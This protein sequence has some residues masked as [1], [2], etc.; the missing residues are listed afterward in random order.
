MKVTTNG[1]KYDVRWERWWI[2]N[3]Y[4]KK[5]LHPSNVE[6]STCPMFQDGVNLLKDKLMVT[7]CIISDI[8]DR[9]SGR[10]KY[11]PIYS[12]ISVQGVKDSPNKFFG[13]KYSFTRALALFSKNDRS[14][15]WK[16]FVLNQVKT[17]VCQ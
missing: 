17:E 2:R 13:R 3:D 1:K 9:K 10:E 16:V 4:S 12:G 15:F 14:E 8:D 7:K 6:K 11:N 5:Q